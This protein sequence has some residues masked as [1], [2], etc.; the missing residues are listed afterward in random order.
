M[1]TFR[2]LMLVSLTLALSTATIHA[3]ETDKSAPTDT[4]TST[5]ASGVQHQSATQSAKGVIYVDTNN[6]HKFDAG[7]TRLVNVR[8]SNGRDIVRTNDRGEY[9]LPVDDD[10][11]IFVIKPRGLRPQLNKFNN[12]LFYYTH[13]PHGSP[14]SQFAGVAPTGDLPESIN[15][16]LYP[17]P[18]PDQFKAILFGDPQPRNQREVD[19]I[20]HDVVQ[21]LVGTDASFGVTLGDIVFDDLA[22]F[23]PQAR[24]I[25]MIGIPW[26]NVI[27][28]HDVNMD[29]TED[30]YSDETFERHF[31]PSYYSFDHGNVHF[32]VLDDVEWFY[33]DGK[34]KG[35]YRG[36]IDDKQLE[37]IKNDL[38][39]IPDDQLVVI[40]MHVPLTDVGNRQTL[41]RLIEKRPACISISAHTHTNEHRII[42][43]Q[44]GWQGPEPHRHI[45]NV[46]VSG[47]WWSG[48]RDERGIPHAT[49]TDG[50]PNGYSII[51][52]DGNKYRL[53]YKAAGKPVDYQLAIYTPNE[54]A[55][56]ELPTTTLWVN[57][58]N[59]TDE[60]TVDYRIDD[61]WNWRPMEKTAAIDPQMQKVIQ[62][63]K[64]ILEKFNY[65]SGDEPFRE[66]P[67]LRPSTHLWKST[68]PGNL[69]PGVH[70]IHVRTVD[71]Y[72]RTYTGQKLI[73]ITKVAA[74]DAAKQKDGD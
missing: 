55:Q 14:K 63:E 51:D 60:S 29:A 58:F 48:A 44:D 42:T 13:K 8:V 16:P 59:G 4:E 3:H 1:M 30:K 45:V 37:F 70:T 9:E 24:A 34:G 12:P 64:D 28:N 53:T 62:A 5:P 38:S 18:E 23:E 56:S 20:A 19:Y 2:Q 61:N 6:D 71:M 52:F 54:I 33:D 47:S 49:M 15:I 67:N 22:M 36:G 74:L 57:V 21:E 10:T 72:G 66:I 69:S 26:F 25:A 40:L 41:Y 50:G 65:E 39:M 7:D 43:K 46:T 11:T 32:L 35:T 73:R 68:L 17:N 31:G 27:G